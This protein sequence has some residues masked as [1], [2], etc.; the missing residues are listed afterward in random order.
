MTDAGQLRHRKLWLG[1]GWCLICAIIYLSLTPHPPSPGFKFG[2]KVGHIS[3]YTL[4]T[5]W[6]LQLY[7][8]SRYWIIALMLI[9]LG[10]SLEIAQSFSPLRH[11]DYYDA[12]ANAAGVALAWL[13]IHNGL[14]PT[15]RTLEKHLLPKS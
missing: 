1:I 4:A 6:M 5:W 3:A 11:F 8:R 9:G 13:V 12:V 14:G 15:L 2:D 7:Q 10:V